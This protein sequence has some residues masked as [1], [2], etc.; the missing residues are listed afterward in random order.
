MCIDNQLITKFSIDFCLSPNLVDIELNLGHPLLCDHAG[1]KNEDE[2]V[3]TA[4]A[5][6]TQLK[7]SQS[8][9]EDKLTDTDMHF[10][11]PSV[12]RTITLETEDSG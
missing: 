1:H 10:L 12:K 11:F 3:A 8:C 5:R 2:Q 6:I 7:I 4:F 9:V